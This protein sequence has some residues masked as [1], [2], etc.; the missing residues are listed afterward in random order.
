M[1]LKKQDSKIKPEFK[2]QDPGVDLKT[3]DT[4]IIINFLEDQIKS[5][6]KPLQDQIKDKFKKS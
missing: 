6:E 1:K 4:N 3:L 5:R 2:I